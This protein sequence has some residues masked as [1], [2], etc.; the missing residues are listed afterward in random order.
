MDTARTGVK[1]DRSRKETKLTFRD[2]S[3]HATFLKTLASP[4]GNAVKNCSP[5]PMR[6]LL[7]IHS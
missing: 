3:W 1:S 4:D 5:Y 7:A 6:R 2:A